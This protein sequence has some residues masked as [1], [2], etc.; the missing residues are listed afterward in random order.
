MRKIKMRNTPYAEERARA[1]IDEC[2]IERLYVKKHKRVEYRFSWWPN[3]RMIPRPLDAPEKTLLKLVE[4]AI[5]QDVFEPS[6]LD[7]L[8]RALAVH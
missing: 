6:A 2:R 7:G 1:E 8:R 4:E 5:K 3:G